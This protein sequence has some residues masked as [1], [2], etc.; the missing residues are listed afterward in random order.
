MTNTRKLT[1]VAVLSALSF[2]LMF[3]QFSFLI[4]FFKID[5]S[6]IAILLALVLLDFKSAVWVTLIRSVLKLALNNKGLETLIGLPINIIGVLV[7]VLA[8]AWIWNKERT[9]G[10][11]VLT[12]IIGTIS[13]SI[14]MVLVNYVYAIP[15]Y[16]RFMNYDISKTLGLVHYLAAMV[17]PFNLIEGV[18]WAIAFG[19]IYTLLQPILK[20][21]EK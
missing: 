5:L 8:F 4:D 16:A 6:I 20:K 10:R 3:Y 15:L 13:L 1:L 9:H 12:T 2:I 21:Y 17:A 19:L 11:F 7:F 18:I 14:T